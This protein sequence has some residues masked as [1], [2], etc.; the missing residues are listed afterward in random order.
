MKK[1][2]WF[3]IIAIIVIIIAILVICGMKNNK[4]FTTDLEGVYNAIISE[5]PKDKV[6]E[7]VLFKETNEEL[8]NS[9]YEGLANIDL[10]EK[11]IYMHPVG[12]ACEIALVKV[13][14]INDMEAVENIFKERI[15]IGTEST[16]CDWETQDIWKRRAEIQ[17]KGNYACLIVLPDGYNIPQDI[18][19]L[20][21]NKNSNNE[22][23]T[24]VDYKSIYEEKLNT[25]EVGGVYS[26]YA[27]YDLDGDNIPEMIVKQGMS[28]ADTRINVYD[29]I[30]GQLIATNIE[31]F[32]GHTNIVGAVDI[33]S[34]IF[35][36]GHGGYEKVA[37]LHYNQA[38]TYTLEII[39]DAELEEGIGYIPFES[40]KMYTFD[41]KEGLEWNQNPDDENYWY[42][43]AGNVEI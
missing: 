13:N 26:E 10:L 36:Y 17:T 19:S 39:K 3:V 16:M 20:D 21:I 14:N 12:H 6:E 1:N 33:N 43:N 18:F 41:N 2:L 31:E 30:D 15:K 28:E 5:Q 22:K 9:Y 7:L 35:Q 27:L 24:S 25:L 32:G 34:I 38:G 11:N 23:E 40:L 4:E 8:I 42:I 29:I 37:V